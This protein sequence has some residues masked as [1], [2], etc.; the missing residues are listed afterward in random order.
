MYLTFILLDPS[1][2][3]PIF[4]GNRHKKFLGSVSV[5]RLTAPYDHHTGPFCCQPI[6]LVHLKCHPFLRNRKEQNFN[7]KYL[8]KVERIYLWMNL[9]LKTYLQEERK[10]I[11]FKRNVS[12]GQRPLARWK[13]WTQW[14][15]KIK[16]LNNCLFATESNTICIP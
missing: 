14:K 3:A 15:Y 7:Q 1:S 4:R 2:R 11:K 8:V 12:E 5:H 10:H 16:K 6:L 13:Q 9:V